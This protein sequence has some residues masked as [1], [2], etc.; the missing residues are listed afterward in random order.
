[1]SALY[2]ILQTYCWVNLI[3]S[4]VLLPFMVVALHKLITKGKPKPLFMIGIMTMFCVCC[5]TNAAMVALF[6]Q[7]ESFQDYKDD[8]SASLYLGTVAGASFLAASWTFSFKNWQAA[9]EFNFRHSSDSQVATRKK[10]RLYFCYNFTGYFL[11]I[12]PYFT[13]TT[14]VVFRP[15]VYDVWNIVWS[16]LQYVAY[17][18]VTAFYL[19]AMVRIR[20]QVAGNPVLK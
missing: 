17:V 19:I 3:G 7:L 6:L 20:K 10:N 9:Y 12:V 8:Y 16:N 4:V 18:Y 2:T 1:M 13:E 11:S 15:K 5:A 14:L